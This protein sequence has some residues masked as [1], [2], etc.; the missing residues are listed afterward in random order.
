MSPFPRE[1]FPVPHPAQS[2]PRML[3]C[4]SHLSQAGTKPCQSFLQEAKLST[5]NHWA[6]SF[7]NAQIRFGMFSKKLSV[8]LKE[9]ESCRLIFVHAGNTR[10]LS[11]FLKKSHFNPSFETTAVFNLFTR[12]KCPGAGPG[13][14]LGTASVGCSHPRRAVPVLSDTAPHHQISAREGVWLRK[15]P[16]NSQQTTKSSLE[17]LTQVRTELSLCP[18]YVQG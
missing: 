2:S 17:R 12:M 6:L 15:R 5:L 11:L 10:D 18:C 13:Q 14:E 9:A 8:P 16:G 1:R 7:I 4:I 3:R